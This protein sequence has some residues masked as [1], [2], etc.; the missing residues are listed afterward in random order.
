MARERKSRV[1]EPARAEKVAR[2]PWN[3]KKTID[4]SLPGPQ[5]SWGTLTSPS[6]PVKGPRRPCPGLREKC[7]LK[8]DRAYSEPSCNSAAVGPAATQLLLAWRHQAWPGPGEGGSV[9]TALV[10]HFLAA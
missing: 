2:V 5:E 1:A 4:N 3:Q 7:R 6:P 8:E 9:E 10:W